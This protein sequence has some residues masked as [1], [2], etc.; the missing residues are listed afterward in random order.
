MKHL[1]GTQCKIVHTHAP[2][3]CF[4]GFALHVQDLIYETKIVQECM[5]THCLNF[6]Q[7]CRENKSS[8]ALRIWFFKNVVIDRQPC[9]TLKM[10]RNSRSTRWCLSPLPDPHA[11]L[12]IQGATCRWPGP[13]LHGLT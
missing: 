5:K 6:E 11:H 9:K 4:F 8:N 3:A 13:K 7:I 10:K 2:Y 12:I 1:S